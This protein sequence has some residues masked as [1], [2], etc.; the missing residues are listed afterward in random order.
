[1]KLVSRMAFPILVLLLTAASVVTVQLRANQVKANLR[2]RTVV[3][4]VYN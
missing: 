1:M 2:E 3:I 4:A